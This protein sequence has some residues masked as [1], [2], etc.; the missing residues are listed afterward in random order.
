MAK[1]MLSEVN[2]KITLLQYL[3]KYDNRTCNE[4]IASLGTCASDRMLL[5]DR[6]DDFRVNVMAVSQKYF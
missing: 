1:K 3:Q 4:S 5:S 2:E 6:I